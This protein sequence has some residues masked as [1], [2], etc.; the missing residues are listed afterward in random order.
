MGNPCTLI[1]SLTWNVAKLPYS[2]PKNNVPSTLPANI[3][4]KVQDLKLRSLLSEYTI[5]T[6]A[7][8]I[9]AIDKTTGIIALEQTSRI[10]IATQTTVPN[11]LL[12]PITT[13]VS[14]KTIRT[15]RLPVA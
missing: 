4:T 11:C 6:T 14:G 2:I 12:C 5:E 3:H 8:T 13:N 1:T 10:S 7:L 9:M 15:I